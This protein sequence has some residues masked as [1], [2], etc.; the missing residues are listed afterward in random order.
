MEIYRGQ[1][2]AAVAS[3][4]SQSSGS[5]VSGARRG[6]RQ[7]FL[8]NHGQVGMASS[9]LVFMLLRYPN[10]VKGGNL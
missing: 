10:L 3:T 5:T 4:I 9:S 1:V 6:G 8:P 2:R 7:H